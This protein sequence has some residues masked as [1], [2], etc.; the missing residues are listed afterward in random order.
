MP[1]FEGAPL[2][3]GGRFGGIPF[4][5]ATPST[6]GIIPRR[7]DIDAPEEDTAIEAFGQNVAEVGKGIIPGA[8]QLGGTALK[9][10]AIGGVESERYEFEL[11]DTLR[12]AQ[13]L[14]PEQLRDAR[15]QAV[16]QPENPAIRVAE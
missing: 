14:T 6:A 11:A 16:R 4:E 7:P 2:E 1:R 12:N 10:V 5:Q 3:T 8:I 13:S 9:G 15:L